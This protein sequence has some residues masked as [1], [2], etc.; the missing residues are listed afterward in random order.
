MT[1]YPGRPA[2]TGSPEFRALGSLRLKLVRDGR[3]DLEYLHLLEQRAGRAAAEAFAR[4]LATNTFTYTQNATLYAEV[5][6]ELALAIEAAAQVA[7]V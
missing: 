4:R 1:R 6:G 5:R 2:I 7:F 3:E